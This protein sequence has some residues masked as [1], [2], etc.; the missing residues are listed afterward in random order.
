MIYTHRE[1]YGGARR[2]TII[3]IERREIHGYIGRTLKKNREGMIQESYFDVIRAT[4]INSKNQK[5][6]NVQPD[7]GQY[8]NTDYTD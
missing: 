3:K 1:S 5:R 8:S 7:S 6:H 2:G 4:V